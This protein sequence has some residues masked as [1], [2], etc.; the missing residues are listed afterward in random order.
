MEVSMEVGGNFHGSGS[1]GSRWTLME[2]LW[3]E[4]EDRDSRGSWMY[5]EEYES[6][7]KL[8][9][10]IFVE[11]ANDGSNGSLH[12]HRRWKLPC[13]SMETYTN[14]HGSKST[15]SDFHG[16]FYYTTDFHGSK[17]KK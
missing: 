17:S 2:V 13:I 14:F 11:A 12:F 6:S 15:S 16:S 3:K 8:P 4:L 7:W 5:V 9:R 1:K 10:N